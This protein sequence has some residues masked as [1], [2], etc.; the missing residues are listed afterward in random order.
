MDQDPAFGFRQLVDI[1]SRALSPGI[2]DPTTAHL[3]ISE[4][5]DLLR[6]LGVRRIP[7]PQR[8]DDEGELRLIVACHD[9]GDL[10]TLACNELRSFGHDS[11]QVV[12]A[13][14]R[15]LRDL[16]TVVPDSRRPAIRLQL[17]RLPPDPS[18]TTA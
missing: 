6:R 11:S 2:N 9:W 14:R 1:G 17:A 10:V 15:M 4:I 12:E 8:V 18:G 5:H 7:G 3:V 13:L 16:D